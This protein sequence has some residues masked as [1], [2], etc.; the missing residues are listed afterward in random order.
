M[1][2]LISVFKKDGID[3]FAKGLSELG[4]EIYSTGG[5]AQRLTEIG[6]DVHSVTELTNFPEIMDGRVKTLN[7]YI[8]GAIL[9]KRDNPQHQQTAKQHGIEMI[10]IVVVNLYPF[11]ETIAKSGIGLDEIIEMIDIGGP[12]MIR[13]AAKNHQDVLIIV[14]PARYEEVLSCLKNNSIPQSLRQ[15]LAIEAFAHTARY[16]AVI[17]NYFRN[18]YQSRN[19]FPQ[20]LSLGLEKVQDLRYGENSHQKAALYRWNQPS[21]LIDIVQLNGKELSFNNYLDT[22][23]AYSIVRQF[24]EPAAVIIKHT[25]PCGVATSQS[26]SEAYCNAYEADSVSAYGG[27]VGLNRECDL[28]TAEEISKIFVEVIVAPGFSS[29]ALQ[30]LKKKS[31]LR[32]IQKFNFYAQDNDFDVRK[33]S[34]GLLVQD[35]DTEAY[36]SSSW[37]CATKRNPS[38]EELA[39]M[40]IGWKVIQFVKSNAIILVKDGIL[41]GV[42]AGQMSRVE[43]VE[44]A[45]KRA[46]E[47]AKGSVLVSDAYFPFADSIELAYKAGITAI[48]QPG[49]SVRDA[50]S[51]KF[52]DDNKMSMMMTGVR[53]FK[54]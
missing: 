2:A 53:H 27:I 24:E 35:K 11:E 44:L 13:S 20:E 22:D 32:L 10:D 4:V 29:D 34:G 5:T 30:L 17:S 43:A 33:I 19:Y 54:H 51:I 42:G 46:G 8:H 38:K 15:E 12:S 1:K 23:A 14:N 18:I 47:K 6:L 52:A 50:D 9:A 45:I 31:N 48:V 49:G 28:K 7:P 26:L 25:N 3:N 37:K 36:C 41:V 39:S 40:E 16:D 21:G